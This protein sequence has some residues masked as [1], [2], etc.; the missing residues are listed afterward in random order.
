M[1]FNLQAENAVERGIFRRS[2]RY[3]LR[4]SRSTRYFE[5]PILCTMLFM[6]PHSEGALTFKGL[7]KEKKYKVYDYTRSLTLGM[8]SGE[9][10]TMNITFENHLLVELTP[11]LNP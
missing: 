2:L 1:D 10:P 5:K 4:S 7:A 3:W 11:I 9:L 6:L 8:V